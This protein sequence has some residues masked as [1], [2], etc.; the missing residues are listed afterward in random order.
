MRFGSYD[1]LAVFEWRGAA[2]NVSRWRV[3]SVLLF[4]RFCRGAIFLRRLI[5]SYFFRLVWHLI[6]ASI[7]SYVLAKRNFEK[8]LFGT[9]L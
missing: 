3:I 7:Y 8:K 4:S 2:D 9:N 6:S 1:S 5:V